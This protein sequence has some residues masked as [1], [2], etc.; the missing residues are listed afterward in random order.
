MKRE[1]D[2]LPRGPGKVPW[3]RALS[4]FFPLVGASGAEVGILAVDGYS[5]AVDVEFNPM[6]NVIPAATYELRAYAVTMNG[7]CLIASLVLQGG[8]LQR[9][10]ACAACRKWEVSVGLLQAAAQPAWNPQPQTS[11]IAHGRERS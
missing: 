9:L 11:A 8:A 7:R 10:A 6:G 4:R 3:R 1:H 2:S 5:T